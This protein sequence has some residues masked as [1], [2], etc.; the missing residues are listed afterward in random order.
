MPSI[1]PQLPP[2]LAKR[3]TSKDVSHDPSSPP[4]KRQAASSNLG[5][6]EP[7]QSHKNADEVTLNLDPDSNN[8]IHDS[9][10]DTSHSRTSS[11]TPP[12]LS[13]IEP[14][15]SRKLDTE[16]S[17]ACSGSG[18]HSRVFGP[19]LP[20]TTKRASQSAAD[21]GDEISSDSEDDYQPPLPPTTGIP[22]QSHLYPQAPQSLTAPLYEETPERRPQRDDWMLAPPTSADQR[23]CNDPTKLRN[24]K[25]RS[26]PSA[27]SAN[28]QLGVS[29]MWTE[30]ADEKLRRLED[31][32]LGRCPVNAAATGS[33]MST[34]QARRERRETQ[35]TEE[36]IQVYNKQ[37]R[38][39]SLL[40]EREAA[41]G[42]GELNKEDADDPSQRGFDREK[43]MALGGYMGQGKRQELLNRAASFGSRF[44][45]GSYL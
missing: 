15:S 39:K 16:D 3:K 24:R 6:A 20:P 44:Q 29:T 43:D 7:I 1:G 31:E 23:T 17:P 30:T 11:P 37:N 14:E 4:C 25:F 40:A 18:K 2:Q 32:V 22:A 19:T 36:R 27:M 9:I 28:N 13:R 34:A 10:K 42:R 35:V 21:S 5:Y 38:N 26:G 45:K 33:K 12:L 8:N 41:Q